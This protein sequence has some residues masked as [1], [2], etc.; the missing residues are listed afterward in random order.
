[1]AFNIQSPA[2]GYSD[3]VKTCPTLVNKKRLK[4][5]MPQQN[6]HL[7]PENE[8]KSKDNTSFIIFHHLQEFGGFFEF[9]HP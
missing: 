4:A 8:P 6:Q 5:Q 1:M 7:A 9:F 2:G 3:H